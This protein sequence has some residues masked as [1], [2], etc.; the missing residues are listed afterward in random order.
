MARDFGITAITVSV[1]RW[2]PVIRAIES[3]E[4]AL[5][6]DNQLLDERLSA[7]DASAGEQKLAADLLTG[8][9]KARKRRLSELLAEDR[10]Q[11][12]AEFIKDRAKH[13]V[14]RESIVA[15]AVVEF[16]IA[17]SEVYTSLKKARE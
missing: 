6:G 3:Q 13:G 1:G 16:D 11:L 14:K 17:T 9:V 2:R 15:D 4:R 10:R 5:Q 12:V 8:R 7:G